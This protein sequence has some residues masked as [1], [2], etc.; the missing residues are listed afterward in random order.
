[1]FKVR[2]LV[3]SIGQRAVMDTRRGRRERPSTLV[4]WF[5]TSTCTYKFYSLSE[6]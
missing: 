3:V 2:K 1:M 6:R 5:V 4:M